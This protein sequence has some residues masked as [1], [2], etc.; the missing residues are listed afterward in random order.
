M[1]IDCGK[2]VRLDYHVQLTEQDLDIIGK[3]IEALV[4]MVTIQN[5]VLQD[6][7]AN[8]PEIFMAGIK[9]FLMYNQQMSKTVIK[10]QKWYNDILKEFWVLKFGKEGKA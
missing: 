2:E 6:L 1:K 9:E 5:S 7:E 8:T 4:S 10:Y 3:A